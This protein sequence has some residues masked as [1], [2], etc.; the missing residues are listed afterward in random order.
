MPP[1][2]WTPNASSES[3]Y[4]SQFFRNVTASQQMMLATTPRPT[5][6]IGLTKPEAGVTATRPAT[7]PVIMPSI[8]GRLLN[9]QSSTAQVMPA[10]APAM[11]VATRAPAASP[12]AARAL[13][14]LNPNQ[15]NHSRPAPSTASG[16]LCGGDIV[17]G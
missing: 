5:A 10:A 17:C 1:M 6:A 9:L 15:P 3:S 12:P 8:V 2:P 7:A 16:R 13:P 14:A 4:F 11:C